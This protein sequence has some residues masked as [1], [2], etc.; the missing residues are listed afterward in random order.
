[1]PVTHF[2]SALGLQARFRPDCCGED[3]AP[4]NPIGG[5]DEEE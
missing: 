1:M 4:Q 5:V 3:L 2:E